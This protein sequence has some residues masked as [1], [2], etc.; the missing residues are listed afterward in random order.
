[1]LIG[2]GH[3]KESGCFLEKI[4]YPT[5]SAKSNKDS[6]QKVLKLAYLKI[7]KPQVVGFHCLI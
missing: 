2:E 3:L 5:S 4:R 1:M 7:L 6:L